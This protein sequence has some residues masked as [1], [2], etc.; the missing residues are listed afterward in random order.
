MVSKPG[1]NFEEVRIILYS[2]MHVI[3]ERASGYR[4]E[5]WQLS[6][7]RIIEKPVFGYGIRHKF[8]SNVPD[9][10]S[11]HNL[12]LSTAYYFGLPTLI[13]FCGLLLQGVRNVRKAFIFNTYDS[14]YLKLVILLYIH[15]VLSVLTDHGQLVRGNTPLWIIFWMPVCMSLAIGSRN[16][17][18][19]TN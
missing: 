17:A 13:I 1:D 8:I 5:L 11:P 3:I 15:A 14:Q 19:Q 6:L 4:L 10:H 18:K 7:E 2:Y 9:G 16:R 12:F